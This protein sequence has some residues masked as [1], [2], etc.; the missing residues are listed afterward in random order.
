M[1]KLFASIRG[2]FLFW[3]FCSEKP[4][5]DRLQHKCKH[6]QYQREILRV[7]TLDGGVKEALTKCGMCKKQIMFVYIS[8]VHK[9]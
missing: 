2:R 7:R 9:A 5:G 6:P 3:R 4:K 8:E 1:K